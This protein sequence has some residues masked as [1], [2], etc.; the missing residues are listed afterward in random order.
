MIGRTIDPASMNRAQLKK[1]D[2]HQVLMEEYKDREKLLQVSKTFWIVK[3]MD[4][5]PGH[6]CERLGVQKVALSYV[7]HEPATPP[8]TLPQQNDNAHPDMTTAENMEDKS[9]MN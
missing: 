2:E 5:V 3:A 4:L 1:F 9:W 6:L 7:I 8:A